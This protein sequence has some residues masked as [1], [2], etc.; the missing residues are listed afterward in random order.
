MDVLEEGKAQGIQ[1]NCKRIIIRKALGQELLKDGS[2]FLRGLVD[3][4]EEIG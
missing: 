3:S 1:G 4:N 2:E